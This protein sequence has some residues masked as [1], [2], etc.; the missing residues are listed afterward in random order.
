ME[1]SMRPLRL[2][3]W[4]SALALSLSA[5]PAE[6]RRGGRAARARPASSGLALGIGAD[7]LVDPEVGELQLTLALE[8][9]VAR[10][11]SAGVRFGAL[12]TTDPTD[13]GAPIDFRLR[14]RTHGL[15]L[16][17]LVGPW[18]VFD[19]GDTLR[20]HGGF[21]F[22]VLTGSTSLGLEVGFLDRT[23]MIGLRV[24]FSL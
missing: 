10:R 15:Y 24:A 19:S 13:V 11:L 2:A 22:G 1:V 18:L 6:A 3:L 12:M 14:L 4:L 16:D 8:R 21:G 23:G 5:V 20:F 17:G 9:A 7:Y